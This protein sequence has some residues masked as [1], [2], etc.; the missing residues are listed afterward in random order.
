MSRKKKR[1]ANRPQSSSRMA[2]VD[3]AS[4]RN[5]VAISVGLAV[6]VFLI[7]A[8]VA[9]FPFINYDDPIYVSE[10]PQV[11][12]GVTPEGIAWAFQATRASNWHPLTWISHMV[13]ASLF[14]STTEPSGQWAGGHHLV[15]VTI[16]ATNSILLFLLLWRMTS[17]TWR[18]ALVAALFAVHP[19]HV[20]SVAWIAERK[21]VLSTLFWLLTT[22]A[23]VATLREPNAGVKRWLVPVFLA[24]GLLAKPMLVTLPFTLLL[25]DWWPLQRFETPQSDDTAP[26]WL[27]SAR[28]LVLEKW[29]LF[30]LVA[31]SCVVTFSVQRAGGAMTM[32]NQIDF[33][34]RVANAMVSA[35]AYLGK[36]LWPL[37]LSVFYPHPLE[38]PPWGLVLAAF[39]TLL[40]ISVAAV[41]NIRRMPYLFVGWFWYLGTLVPVI[42]LVQVGLQAMADRYTYI[43]LIGIFIAAVWGV[44][45]LTDRLRVPTVAR[46]IGSLILITALGI[47]AYRQ[48]GKWSSSE[49]LF[50]HALAVTNAEANYVGQQQLAVILLQSGRPEEAL[51]HFQVAMKLAP[52][53][54]ESREGA[55]RAQLLLG[56]HGEAIAIY[57]ELLEIRPDD[58]EVA[59]NLAWELATSPHKNLRNGPEAVALAER[60][61]NQPGGRTATFLDTLAAAYAAAGRFD[62]AVQAALEARERAVAARNGALVQ[63]LDRRL[64]RYRAGRAFPE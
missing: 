8:Q 47:T 64:P 30:L 34:D 15:N 19:L 1:Q 61:V 16:H 55:A 28:R 37:N 50:R 53:A 56:R 48:V 52:A 32:G 45:E 26:T 4:K 12:D 63:D 43:P 60:I 5:A 62:E 3:P 36:A 18:A 22:L 58:L 35:V 38:S 23:Y 25:L 41:L 17:A 46:T 13:D 11:L 2:P 6:L 7:Y 42:G 40:A 51:K 49:R 54:R 29:L 14:R 10:T 21:D 9:T 59:N 57:R 20:E 44:A 24:L 27:T 31:I 39:L 33:T